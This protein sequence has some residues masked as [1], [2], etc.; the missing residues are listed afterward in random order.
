MFARLVY[1]E[2]SMYP[3]TIKRV[4]P[5]LKSLKTELGKV[6]GLN[7]YTVFNNWDRGEVGV[8]ALW[9]SE[10]DEQRAWEKIK[11]RLNEARD[12]MWRGRPMFKSFDVYDHGTP[13]QSSSTGKT[14][15]RT[16]KATRRTTG[17]TKRT[18]KST[19]RTTASPRPPTRRS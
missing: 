14:T 11:D 18:A 12:I 10:E 4:T 5:L 19:R 9:D 13:S 15:R 1:A 2:L 8:F 17:S 3:D 16:A 7:S 6:Q